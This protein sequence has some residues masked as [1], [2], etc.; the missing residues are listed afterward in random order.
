MERPRGNPTKFPT[1]EEI[2]GI[3]IEFHKGVCG[4]HHAWR[5]TTYNIL[6]AG[7]YWPSLFSDV[8]GLVRSCVEFQMLVGK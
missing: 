4:G 8:N 2:E 1:E 6:R 5:S 3:I 7:Y